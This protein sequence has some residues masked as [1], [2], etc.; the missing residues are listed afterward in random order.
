MNGERP[1]TLTTSGFVI[2]PAVFLGDERHGKLR[3][4]PNGKLVVDV[5]V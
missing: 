5:R 3:G 4:V 1:T 2:H